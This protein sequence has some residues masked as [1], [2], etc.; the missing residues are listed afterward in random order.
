MMGLYSGMEKKWDAGKGGP[1]TQNQNLSARLWRLM[2]KTLLS[3]I[4][5]S[6]IPM[7][8]QGVTRHA[9]HRERRMLRRV[10]PVVLAAVLLAAPAASAGEAGQA[11]ARQ[12]RAA[13]DAMVKALGGS[14]WLAVKNQMRQGSVAAF[15]QNQPSNDATDYGE[16]HAWPD[17]DRIEYGKR[18]DVVQ[19]YLAR[20]GVEVTYKGQSPLPAE[21]VND[22]LRR[23]DHSIE[24]VVKLW[25]NDP[26]TILIYEGQQ[27]AERHLADQVTLISAGDQ[28]VT[29]LM[30]AESH[31]PLRRTFQWRDPVYKDMNLDAEEYDNYHTVDGLP[32]PFIITRYKNGEM[33]RQYF[34]DRVAYNQ[35]LPPDFW[36]VAAAVQRIKK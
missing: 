7:K 11:N 26:K 5:I 17:Q 9:L 35:E 18:R 36:S 30:D 10:L 28:A 12:A 8:Q 27:L 14:R 31:L 22:F 6:R 2:E 3:L 25:L 13:L 4:V 19:F 24:T 20:A 23:R 32:T 16:V 15:F 1:G 21:Q 33:V 34:F 29:I